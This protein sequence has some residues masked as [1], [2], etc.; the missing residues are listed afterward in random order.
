MGPE[1]GWAA[2]ASGGPQ[3]AR[4]A[5][6]GHPRLAGA[7]GGRQPRLLPQPGQPVKRR[8]QA[9]VQLQRLPQLPPGGRSLKARGAAGQGV[10]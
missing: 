6:R 9:R 1:C 4:T 10:L 7:R 5:I 8:L 2:P 3:P